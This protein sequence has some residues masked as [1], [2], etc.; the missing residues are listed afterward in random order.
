MVIGFIA[1]PDN[2]PVVLPSLDLRVWLS[3]HKAGYVLAI[4]KASAPASSAARAASRMFP[5]TGAILT[6]RGLREVALRAAPTTLAIRAGL[7]P[8]SAPPC[9]TLGQEMFSS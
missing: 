4:V 8:N 5:T 1:A 9:S 6:H 3:I 7:L 2:P